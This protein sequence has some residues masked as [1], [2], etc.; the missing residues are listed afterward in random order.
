MTGF[1]LTGLSPHSWGCGQ[2]ERGGEG[3]EEDLE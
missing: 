1:D 2:E 3:G